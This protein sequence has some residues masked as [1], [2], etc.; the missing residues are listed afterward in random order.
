MFDL[1]KTW[2]RQLFRA[3]T[4]FPPPRFNL[5][6]LAN[7]LDTR[8]VQLR[9]VRRGYRTFTIPKRRG[10][11]RT[12]DAPNPELK[13]LQRRILQRVLRGLR[14]HPCACGFERGRSIADNALPHVGAQVVI[15]LDLQ[16]FFAST[17]AEWVHDYFRHVGFDG[18][19]AELLTD[20]CTYNGALPQGAPTSPRLS[21][22]INYR[23]DERM[24]RAAATMGLVYTR[25]ADDITLSLPAQGAVQFIKRNPQTL[26][27]EPGRTLRPNAVIPVVKRIIADEGYRLHQHRKLRIA[28]RHQ[29]QKVTGLVV[30]ERLNLPRAARRR[31]RAVEH[32]LRVGRSATLTPQQLAGWRALEQMIAK[33]IAGAEE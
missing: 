27:H 21:N 17:K 13:R 26:A 31:L 12:I 3:T 15:N 7:R 20:L 29:R 32:H 33:R 24:A 10:G 1:L 4:P 8:V 11:T 2:F 16:E 18:E 25:Y 22:L 28:R 23:L 6:D 5:E 14:A 9:G 30:N 19:S